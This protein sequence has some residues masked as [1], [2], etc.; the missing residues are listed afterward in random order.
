MAVW[1]VFH[2]L[3]TH[4]EERT[5]LTV[6]MIRVVTRAIRNGCCRPVRSAATAVNAEVTAQN[7]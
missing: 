5:K 3:N 4:L 1:L 2:C 7:A 6:Y